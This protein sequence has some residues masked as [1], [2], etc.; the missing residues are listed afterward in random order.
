MFPCSAF[1][2]VPTQIGDQRNNASD[3]ASPISERAR[4]GIHPILPEEP[5]SPVGQYPHLVAPVAY[6][7][8]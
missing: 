6:P 7:S 4:L 5:Q 8:G 1:S 3:M 2:T